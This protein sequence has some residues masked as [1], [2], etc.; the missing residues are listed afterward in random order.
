MLGIA[1]FD[2][3]MQFLRTYTLSHTSSRIDV[4]LGSRLF[5]HVL[6]LPLAYF[7]SRPT[8]QTVARL[9]ELETIRAFLT[10]QG[11]SSAIDLIFT[12]ILVAILFVYS[13]MLAVI[14]LLAIPAYVL[15]ASLLRPLLRA[16]INER[17]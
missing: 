13:V 9:R 1:L 7:E 6:R 5:D 14:A 10:G 16:K 8:G 15:I 4:E 17:F 2:A 12:V 3:L 11:L